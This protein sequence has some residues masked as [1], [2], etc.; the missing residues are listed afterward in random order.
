MRERKTFAERTKVLDSDEAK[1]KFFLVYEGEE[2]EVIYFDAIN[3]NRTSLAINPLI[4]L[5]PLIRDYGEQ[6]WSNPKK[7]VDRVIDNIE[8]SQTGVITYEILLNRIMDY[9][10]DEKVVIGRPQCEMAWKT[11]KWVCD[12]KCGKKLNEIV[13]EKEK[14]CEI[15]WN[16]FLEE[17]SI[18]KV[19]DNISEIIEKS[20]I[21]YTKD[22]D[23]ICLIVDR[24]K[25]SFVVNKKVNQYQ[26]V[27]DA[28]KKHGFGFYVTNPCFEFWLLLHFDDVGSLDM[29][30]LA[31]NIKITSK[32]KYTETELCKRISY[33]KSKYDADALVMMLDKAIENE[34][35]FCEDIV[36]LENTVGS[37]VGSLLSEIRN[38]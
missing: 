37:N 33:K 26:S 16:T 31:E 6:G 27:L 2:T 12:V 10:I 38:K 1:R 29:S 32:K 23:K 18:E 28:C 34:K 15:I 25:K 22:F 19:I 21:T 11:L 4:E 5:V 36:Q 9:L 7:I 3:N 35:M 20:A 24:D 13:S 30:K 17:T 14:D 8:E